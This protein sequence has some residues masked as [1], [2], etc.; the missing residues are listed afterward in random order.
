LNEHYLDA[1]KYY[2]VNSGYPNEYD[3]LG[4]YRGER[5]H[6]P[7]RRRGQPQSREEIFNRV[8][9]SLRCVIERAFR[10]WKKRWR[11]L[12]NMSLFPCKTQVQIVVASMALHNYIRRKSI[13][14]VAFNEFDCHPN[15]VLD[16][17]LTDV[18]PRSQTCGH[19]RASCM[20]YVRDGI[21][22]SLMGQ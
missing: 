19:Q 16:D 20:D 1:E 15:F 3:Y 4:P 5:Y 9:S 12:Q 14:D 8:H 17:I 21:A 18:V 22:T 7:I 6:L 11:I 13:Q 10:V 2:L